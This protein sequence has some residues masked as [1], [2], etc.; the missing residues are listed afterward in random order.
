MK[1]KIKLVMA[2]MAA[3]LALN[4]SA[5]SLDI[6][7]VPVGNAG[8]APDSRTTAQGGSPGLGAVAYNYRIGTTE[9]TAGQY[10]EFLNEVASTNDA[11]GLYNTSMYSSG[12]GCGIQRTD[13][14]DGT[15]SYATTKGD[16]MPVNHVSVYDA[17]RFCNWLTT[18]NTETGVYEFSGAD[19][20]ELVTRNTN[21]WN[22]G[23]VAVPSLD[24]WYKAA[25]YQGNGTYSTYANG[26][27]TITTNEANYGYFINTITDVFAYGTKSFYGAL[28]LNGNV[29]NWT[30]CIS[31]PG[32]LYMCGGAFDNP[33]ILLE[34][35]AYNDLPNFYNYPTGEYGSFGIRVSCLRPIV[36][37]EVAVTFF[38]Q[39]GTDPV[40]KEQKFGR[41]Y[42]NFPTPPDRGSDYTF[43]GW[44]TKP[45]LGGVQVQE[46]DAVSPS[47]TAL[48]ARWEFN[49]WQ[50]VRITDGD[51]LL[52]SA[53]N[54]DELTVL[55]IEIEP[56]K[57]TV[58]F[59]KNVEHSF[60]FKTV[61]ASS[62]ENSGAVTSV[63][64]SST[65]TT[66]GDA[67]FRQCSFL[68]DLKLSPTIDYIGANAFYGAGALG[69][70]YLSASTVDTGAFDNSGASWLCFRGDAPTAGTGGFLT[71]T[72]NIYYL[73]ASRSSWETFKTRA[74]P[75]HLPEHVIMLGSGI[76]VN[77][78]I[79]IFDRGGQNGFHFRINTPYTTSADGPEY[80]IVI[81]AKDQLTDSTWVNIAT[82]NAVSQNWYTDTDCASYSNR[83]YKT[84]FLRLTSDPF[85]I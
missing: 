2:G 56:T 73:P 66:I 16:N 65:I 7:T 27:N 63:V 79:G 35:S 37:S 13:N 9:V 10:T 14:G 6:E 34:A 54:T 70:V 55:D 18:G 51:W 19:R 57:G 11:F 8:N 48:F 26:L 84:T 23:G 76:D 28:D 1:I 69:G 32:F 59:A 25:Y 52:D 53:F 43:V 36:V 29:W 41:K 21:A 49:G 64:F 68:S 3:G 12:N 78:Q 50:V 80:K 72:K 40:L 30:D 81:S 71:S 33:V 24:E 22:A 75:R 39:T 67:A 85:G 4:A 45:G 38:F 62:F 5:Y 61:G 74:T 31:A 44:F 15:Y 47:I 46:G 58:N 20:I 83:F 17:M 82:N 42:T 60:L 77:E